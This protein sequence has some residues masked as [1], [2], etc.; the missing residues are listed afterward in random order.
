MAA[1]FTSRIFPF[2]IFPPPLDQSSP[3]KIL[4][5]FGYPVT[6]REQRYSRVGGREGNAPIIIT[7]S[8]SKYESEAC[9]CVFFSSLNF[10]TKNFREQRINL[11]MSIRRRVNNLCHPPVIDCSQLRSK[12][13]FI[14]VKGGLFFASQS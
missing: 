6:N 11:L 1:P 3:D 2:P 13:E 7:D 8:W 14:E 10:S 5:L 12:S 4:F 9:A